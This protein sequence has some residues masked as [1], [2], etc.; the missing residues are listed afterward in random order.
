MI[1]KSNFDLSR[2]I[3]FI[4]LFVWQALAQAATD[5]RLTEITQIPQSECEALIDLYHNTDGPNWTDNLGWNVTNTPCEWGGVFYQI[6]EK[7]YEKGV[8]C[9]NGHVR[10]V[11][12]YE[13]NLNGPIPESITHLERLS[14]LKLGKNNLGGDEARTIPDFIGQLTGLRTLSLSS[15][16]FKGP[17]PDSLANLTK[18]WSLSLSRNSIGGTLP[19]FLGNMLELKTLSMNNNDLTGTLQP[20][21]NLTKLQSLWLY[22]NDLSGT[23]DILATFT[24]LVE[25][26]LGYNEFTGTLPDGIGNLSNLISL[27]LH[28]NKIEGEIPES[29]GNLSL[30]EKLS[31]HN[32]RLTGEIPES[33][34][35]LGQL[36]ILFLEK[37]QLTGTI[38]SSLGNL[39][40]LEMLHLQY[41]QLTGSIPHSLGQLINLQK[42]WLYKNQLTGSIPDSLGNLTQLFEISLSNN[43]LS[44]SIPHTLSNLNQLLRLSLHKNQLSGSIPDSLGHLNS[45]EILKLYNNE[46]CGEI[47]LSLMNLSKLNT[48]RLENNHLTASDS[49]LRNW[50]NNKNEKEN[51]AETQTPCFSTET[52]TIDEK[53]EST[54]LVYALHDGGLNDSQIFTINP[55]ND[56][57]INALG[58][59]HFGHDIEG[60][61]IDPNTQTIYVSSGDNPDVGLAQGYIYQVDKLDGTLT[62]FCSTGFADISAMSFHPQEHRLW[63]WANGDGL[64]TIEV[65][66]IENGVC[67]TTQKIAS[68]AKIEGITWDNQGQKLYGAQRRALY[69]YIYET[70]TLEKSCD[71]FPSDVEALSMLA[72][73]SLLFAVH[74][75]NDTGI[76]A[77]DIESCSIAE[78]AFLANSPYNDIEGISWMCF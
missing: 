18:L 37:N 33:L 71:R 56:F 57:E 78:S 20:L 31:L 63:V 64:F 13:N 70:G 5:C 75:S 26:S 43:Q 29:W 45:L 16:H 32:N 72:N 61:A 21:E 67:Q 11:D 49:G 41:N 60:M 10:G 52:Q 53:V 19:A 39:T 30:L 9:K 3:L 62:P 38:P 74:Q 42:L 4:G 23:V 47:P 55:N 54:C 65:D 34:G 36:K 44:G 2:A 40:A 22:T 15:N 27:S 8:V 24:H 66:Q 1:L 7:T 28:K 76:H 50:L 35:H 73:D 68:N 6:R 51:W 12:L 48:L 25:A 77:F 14:S 17:L 58:E 59:T 46:L 69:E